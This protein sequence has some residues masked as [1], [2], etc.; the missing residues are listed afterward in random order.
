MARPRI[1]DAGL[2][3]ALL[4]A[5]AASVAADGVAALNLR[6]LAQQCGT[7]TSAVYSLFGSKDALLQATARFSSESFRAAQEAVPET[8]SPLQDLHALGLAYHDWAIA[9]PALFQLMFSGVLDG[10]RGDPAALESGM[11]AIEPLESAVRR[12]LRA[13]VLEAGSERH[14]VLA[15]W[16]LVHCLTT[17]ELTGD[18]PPAEAGAEV[19]H[20]ALAAALRGWQPQ[21]PD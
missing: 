19:W 6:Q 3:Q 14:V 7:S 1:H 8:D 15:L 5:T 16:A 11:A 10:Y 12:G 13:G 21:R 2:R 18:C 17:L 9:N 4:E 20:A